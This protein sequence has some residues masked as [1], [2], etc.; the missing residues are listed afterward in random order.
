MSDTKYKKILEKSY[1]DLAAEVVAG[2]IKTDDQP[3]AFQFLRILEKALEANTQELKENGNLS[4]F[5]RDLIIKLEFVALPSLDDKEV[6][7]LFKNDFCNQFKL[8]DYNLRRKINI[9]FLAIMLIESRNKLKEDLRRSLLENVEV[10]TKNSEIK[11]V[12]DWLKSYTSKIGLE[13]KDKLARAQYLVS[14]KNNKDIS[15]EEVEHLKVLFNFF[16]EINIPSDEPDGLDEEYPMIING[17]L[18]I[19]RK[20]VL[21]PVHSSKAIEEALKIIT[22]QEWKAPQRLKAILKT[23]MF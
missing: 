15:S 6:T 12:K 21:E 22:H 10:I 2:I 13:S 20:G 19:F 4:Q 3:K 9:K 14:L 16:D 5:Y 8:T 23:M 18:H 7:S 11:T 17:K 1:Q